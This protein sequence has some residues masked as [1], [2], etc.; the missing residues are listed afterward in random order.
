MDTGWRDVARE[1]RH[2]FV[3]S[4]HLRAT[5]AAFAASSVASGLLVAV[6]PLFL[7]GLG[8]SFMELGAAMSAVLLLSFAAQAV[9][10]RDAARFGRP[11]VVLG[12]LLVSA[13]AFP[14]Y[15]LVQ[16]P[17]HFLLVSAL[18][19]LPAAAATPGLQALMAEAAGKDGAAAV[20]SFHGVLLSFSFA[21]GVVLGGLLL[22]VG[23]HAVFLA[24]S[25][26]S[27][28]AFL[29]LS[30]RVLATR[31]RASA[32]PREGPAREAWEALRRLE[33]RAR[34]HASATAR[35]VQEGAR[36]LPLP[37][38]TQANVRLAALH[39]FAFGLSI[40]AYPVFLPRHFVD[41]GVPEPWIGLV[42]AGSWI[43]FGLAQPWGA[44]IAM[45]TGRYRELVVG[46]L[47]AAALLNVVMALAPLPWAIAAWVL[48]GV[49]DG[50]GRPITG[51]ILLSLT[52]PTERM[53]L[54]GWTNGA[55]TAA[56]LA[57]PLAMATLASFLG[58]R[59]ALF[60]MGL[61]M[62]LA[63]LPL[64]AL[65]PPPAPAAP[66]PAAPAPSTEASA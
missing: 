5:L 34:D 37:L 23:F 65:R 16:T 14:L 2:A 10:G 49:A 15:A 13:C 62:G 35:A 11:G 18:A 9:A 29:A 1:M 41:E 38:G 47:V 46:S 27:L 19:A 6:L 7:T 66:A 40:A 43:T 25:L 30:G 51:A 20:F 61:T 3:R 48:L 52:P 32:R 60:L 21:A 63:L 4:P 36:D 8:F 55:S 54:F 22:V 42:V 44:R 56:R 45:K 59:W 57:G 50:V 58:F 39:L 17:L 64:L 26:L 24:G 33:K 12:L 53:R 31:A 28:T